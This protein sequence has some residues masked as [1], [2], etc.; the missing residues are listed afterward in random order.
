MKSRTV[1]SPLKSRAGKT[2][3]ADHDSDDTT[4]T[5]RRTNT[6]KK[7]K[8]PSMPLTYAL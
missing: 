8:R 3:L 6:N 5:L 2:Y 1:I 4:G 7:E